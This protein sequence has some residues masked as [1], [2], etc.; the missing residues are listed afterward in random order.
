[1]KKV[2]VKILVTLCRSGNLSCSGAVRLERCECG[3]ARERGG[4]TFDFGTVRDNRTECE[5]TLRKQERN[6]ADLVRHLTSAKW[7]EV[8][9]WKHFGF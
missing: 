7:I 2:Q 3:P 4:G 5:C 8:S 9:V 6:M 1:M